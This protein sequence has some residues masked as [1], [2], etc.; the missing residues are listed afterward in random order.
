M[1]TKKKGKL[2]NMCMGFCI[3]RLGAKCYDVRG[4]GTN[5]KGVGGYMMRK[6]LA[7][8]LVLCMTAGL[9]SCKGGKKEEPGLAETE[10]GQEEAAPLGNQRAGR[11]LY[12]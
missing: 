1:C 5:G 4:N 2:G 8:L 10:E 7:V 3:V 9:A 6:V 11:P 12:A